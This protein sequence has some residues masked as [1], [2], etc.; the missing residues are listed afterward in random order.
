MA[1]FT[2]EK[3][4]RYKATITLGMLQSFATNEMVADKLKE[5]GFTDVSVTGSGKTRIAIG[6]WDRDTVSG[7]IPDEI[8][9]ITM[10]A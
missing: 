4:K 2:V 5:T 8:S 10:V 9:E 3:G 1:D 7:A 6:V